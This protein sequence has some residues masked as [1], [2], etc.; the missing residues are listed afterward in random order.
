MWN[1]SYVFYTFHIDPRQLSHHLINLAFALLNE[2][3]WREPIDRYSKDRGER[4]RVWRADKVRLV[5]A[6]IGLNLS[7]T[8]TNLPVGIT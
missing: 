3:P 2:I 1:T 5:R 7:D 6:I 8:I 4:N